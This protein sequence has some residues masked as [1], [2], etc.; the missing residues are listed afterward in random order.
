M[1][2]SC[3]TIANNVLNFIIASV[4]N[5]DSSNEWTFN[6]KRYFY[7]VGRENRDGAIT[8]TV[9]RF[10]PDGVHVKRAGSFRIEPEGEISRFPHV[11]N[12]VRAKARKKLDDGDFIPPPIIRRS[13]GTWGY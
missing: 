2:Y 4:N 10:Q 13:V 5:T 9:W 3:S 7:E 6:G 11:P 12:E 8:G 1:G